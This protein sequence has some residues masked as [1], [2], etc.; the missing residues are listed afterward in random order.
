VR[1]P[2]PWTSA[3]PASKR[4]WLNMPGAYMSRDAE[5][6]ETNECEDVANVKKRVTRRE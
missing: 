2:L 6:K 3:A 5:E 4:S 1:E